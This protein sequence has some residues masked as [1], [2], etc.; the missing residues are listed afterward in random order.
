MTLGVKRK[1][2]GFCRTEALLSRTVNGHSFPSIPKSLAST[3]INSSLAVACLGKFI[4]VV[5]HVNELWRG[6]SCE[7]AIVEGC[8]DARGTVGVAK[9]RGPY[10][11]S[12][13]FTRMLTPGLEAT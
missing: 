1:A 11:T 3:S 2:S 6:C 9:T 10:S 5:L 12:D 4:G 7:D 13:N 8:S